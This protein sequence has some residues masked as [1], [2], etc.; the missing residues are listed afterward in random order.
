M[1]PPDIQR[2]IMIFSHY[3]VQSLNTIISYFSCTCNFPSGSRHPIW[4]FVLFSRVN[5]THCH[6]Q[7]LSHH[8]RAQPTQNTAAHGPMQGPGTSSSHK[9]HVTRL[10]QTVFSFY[11]VD[12]ICNKLDSCICSSLRGKFCF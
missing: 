8:P 6:R 10:Q 5:S 11:L 3:K 2:I 4:I 7:R 9:R 1:L 12:H